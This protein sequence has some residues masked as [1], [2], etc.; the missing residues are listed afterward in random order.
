[1]RMVA[2]VELERCVTRIGVLKV[3]LDKLR[4]REE[5]YLVILLTIY[6]GI[7]ICFP[8]AVLAF[9]PS[10]GL[11]VERIRESLLNAKEVIEQGPKLGRKI[12]FSVTY[13]GVRKVVISYHHVYDYFR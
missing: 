12:R 3:L 6:E 10:V 2:I 1:M 11:M 5:L 9:R 8:R 4:H 7:K 13:D